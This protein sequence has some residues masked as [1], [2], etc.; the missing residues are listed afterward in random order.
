MGTM[1][2]YVRVYQEVQ[3]NVIVHCPF[4]GEKTVISDDEVP[5]GCKHLDKDDCMTPDQDGFTVWYRDTDA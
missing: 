5:V 2:R 4:C 1:V 3:G